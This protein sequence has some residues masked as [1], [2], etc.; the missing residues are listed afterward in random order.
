MTLLKIIIC[1]YALLMIIASS[2]SLIKD[3]DTDK[4]FHFI[5]LI[6]SI[7]LIVS[8]VIVPKTYLVVPVAFVLV[9]YQ[10]LA[11]YRGVSLH[12]F[13]WQHHVVRLILTVALIL[14]LVYI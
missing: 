7:A 9:G 14:T 13:H 2:Q 10:I 4:M 3:H 8:L 5:N 1:S 6:I 12:S 11:I